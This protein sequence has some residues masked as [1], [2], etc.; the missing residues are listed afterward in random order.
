[1]PLRLAS[2]YD[3]APR[4]QMR[5][6]LKLIRAAALR[7]A[8]ANLRAQKAA[9]QAA[10]MVTPY[11]VHSHICAMSMSALVIIAIFLSPLI[12]MPECIDRIE[13]RCFTRHP[14][15]SVLSNIVIHSCQ[16]ACAQTRQY[17]DHTRALNLPSFFQCLIVTKI[18]TSLL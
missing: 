14:L 5:Q 11:F 13:E 15:Q 18:H 6:R 16:L 1:M 4:G 17:N 8:A 9:A 2:L 3:V 7:F 12:L 10:D